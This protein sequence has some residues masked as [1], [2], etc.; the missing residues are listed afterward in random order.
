ME[1][2]VVVCNKCP[3]PDIDGGTAATRSL[4]QG[5]LDLGYDVHALIFDT[6]KHPVKE[7][8]LF[9]DWKQKKFTYKSIKV[10]T[11]IVPPCIIKNLFF[12]KESLH[13]SRVQVDHVA[14]KIN[15]ALDA[16]EAQ[17]IV[18]DGLF[19]L[20]Q[21]PFVHKKNRTFIYRAHNVEY[22]VWER[23]A[24]NSNFP[25]SWYINLMTERLNSFETR[26]ISY[27]DQ[28][29]AISA[30]TA[31]FFSD[32]NV[33]TVIVYPTF[34]ISEVSQ[35]QKNVQGG[36]LSLFHIGAMDWLPNL[37]A[38]D[39]FYLEILPKYSEAFPNSTFYVG[40]RNFPKNRYVESNNFKVV[41]EVASYSEFVADMDLLV[42]P[43]LSG[44]GIRMKIGETMGL[45]V[46]VIA[47]RAAMEGIPAIPN[48]HYLQFESADE[49]IAALKQLENDPFLYN[50][51]SYE[52]RE[53]ALA[54]FSKQKL[55]A[56]LFT[57]LSQIKNNKD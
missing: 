3:F 45:G 50:K 8:N 4:I 26:V 28:V 54:C 37:E 20:A 25:K 57:L 1:K 53:L 46:P 40:G 41:G 52:G 34:A 36:R 19:A 38:I 17:I 39:Y 18:F 14:K 48:V 49:F 12:S 13:I 42:V 5:L 51:L 43:L 33:N 22:K 32:N 11:K 30:D 56:Q 23:V 27:I 16:I 10:N 31:S 29:W 44:S 21:I 35:F 7:E 9:A 15:E 24:Q 47:T 2:I 6:H 55:N